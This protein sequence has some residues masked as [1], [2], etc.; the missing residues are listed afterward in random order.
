VLA[1]VTQ[2]E[3]IKGDAKK[4]VSAFY[5]KDGEMYSIGFVLHDLAYLEVC[6]S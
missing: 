6:L 4:N 2:V 3:G 1:D 5:E